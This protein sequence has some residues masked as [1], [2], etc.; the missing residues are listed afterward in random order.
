MTVLVHTP[1]GSSCK[2]SSLIY[3]FSNYLKT[4]NYPVIQLTCNGAFSLC[5][6]D[7]EEGWKRQVDS[8][9]RCIKDQKNLAEWSGSQTMDLSKFI[10]SDE[11]IATRRAINR[12]AVSQLQSAA[13]EGISLYEICLASFK[14]RYPGSLPDLSNKKHEQLLRR[15]L[16]SA[17]RMC[18]A[19]KRLLNTIRPEISLVSSGDDYITRSLI[20]QT[21]RLK[22][23]A[24]IFKM[25]IHE[26]C[27][28]VI[29]TA[30]Q[31]EFSSP[32][33]VNEV[34]GMRPDVDT[35]PPQLMQLMQDI[36]RFLDVSASQISLPLAQ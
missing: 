35:W 14:Q 19:S 9:L 27:I 3:L 29:N 30:R 8:C 20:E 28:K 32:L 1:Y 5:D 33:V 7:E 10:S 11:V 18:M 2:E 12:F 34:I 23:T 16:L 15:Y 4:I 17:A 21:K 24:V 36:A 6:R 31:T 25:D 22:F 13:Y 26:R